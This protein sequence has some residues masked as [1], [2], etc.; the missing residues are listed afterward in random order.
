MRLWLL[1]ATCCLLFGPATAHARD[2]ASEPPYPIGQAPAAKPKPHHRAPKKPTETEPAAASTKL[3]VPRPST[4]AKGDTATD[5]SAPRPEPFAKLPADERAA[6]RSALLWSSG[7]D[8]KPDD[9]EDPMTAAIKAYQKRNKAKVTGILTDAERNELLAAAKAHREEFGWSVALDPATGIRLGIPNKLVP[10]THEAENGTRWSARHGE[11]AIETF[12]I[13]TRESLTALF[14]A[15]RKNP[16]KRKVESSYARGDTFFIGGM[17]GLKYFAVRAQLKDGELRGYTIF[18]DQAMEGIMLPVLRAIANAFAP[19]PEDTMPVAALSRPVAYGTGV[20][21]SNGGDIITNR[22]FADGCDVITVPGLGHAEHTAIDTTHG[23]A[24]LRVY[25]KRK[26]NAAALADGPPQRDIK[27]TGI[28]DP[29][30]QNGNNFRST[31]AAQLTDGNAV[32]LRNP[33]P[34]AGFSGAPALDAEGRVLGIMEMHGMQL[35]SVQA[36]V[37]PVRLIPAATI[38]DFLA[39]HNVTPPASGAGEA[40][41]VRVICIHH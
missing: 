41:I 24:L 12:R 16:A 17:Q 39:A 15:Q 27:V 4:D 10:K 13:K 34:L 3:P 37:P 36:A 35:A 20:I 29:N 18:Y 26:L 40:A 33:I 11:V 32:R 2:V 21:V 22:R 19:F 5:S 6:I 9:G 38:R 28:A 7:E 25:G 14:E 1:L 30:I 31:I 8:G 23:L